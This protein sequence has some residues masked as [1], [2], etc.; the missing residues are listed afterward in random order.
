MR[1]QHGLHAGLA[2]IALSGLALA[3]WTTM[4]PASAQDNPGNPGQPPPGNRRMMMGG[5]STLAASGDFV[6]VL[7]GNTLFQMKAADLSV[8]NQK[9]LPGP[10]GG[11][12]EP[13]PPN[14]RG[15]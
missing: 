10:R 2:L 3:S 12:E 6:Y 8:I 5:P 15:R 4:R 11:G 7:R 14:P 9:E 13:P 1:T